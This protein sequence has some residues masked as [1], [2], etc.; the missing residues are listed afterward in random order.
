MTLMEIKTSGGIP[1]WM[2]NVLT[3][4]HIYKTSFS[5]YGSAYQNMLLACCEGSRRYA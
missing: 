3:R 4:Q 1:L 2:T 5:K